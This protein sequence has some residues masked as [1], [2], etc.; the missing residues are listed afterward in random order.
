MDNRPAPSTITLW[1][2]E[3]E[4]SSLDQFKMMVANEQTDEATVKAEF[5]RRLG[6][7]FKHDVNKA[8]DLTEI[9][10]LID[11]AKSRDEFIFYLEN[12]LLLL[13]REMKQSKS[14]NQQRFDRLAA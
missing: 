9:F 14:D 8:W 4:K 7:C 1:L 6:L 13:S 10:S 3:D 12:F 5:I 2:Q 11:Q